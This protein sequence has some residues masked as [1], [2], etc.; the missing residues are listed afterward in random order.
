MPLTDFS[1]LPTDARVWV[2]ACDRPLA[3]GP[4]GPFLAQVDAYLAQ[5]K[6]HGMPLRCARDWRDDRFL[7][8]GIDP[9]AEQ[10]SGCSIDD[11]F[12]RLRGL[13]DAIGTQVLGG[14]RVFYRDA[15]GQ[16]RS[17]SRAEFSALAARGDVTADTPI[18]DTSVIVADAWRARFERRAGDA[19]TRELLGVS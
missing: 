5:W 16:V 6:A 2:F 17:A 14:G 4:A 8:I 11:L 13:G 7:A 18:F 1:S 3:A 19:W 10:A 9:T 15:R 12:R